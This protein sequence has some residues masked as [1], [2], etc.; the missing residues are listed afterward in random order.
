MQNARV[1]PA[2]DD[3]DDQATEMNNSFTGECS[4][5]ALQHFS[6]SR[7]RFLSLFAEVSVSAAFLVSACVVFST[8]AA[9]VLHCVLV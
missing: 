1:V 8:C 3:D 5:A 9:F 7:S 2:D 6:L 4:A